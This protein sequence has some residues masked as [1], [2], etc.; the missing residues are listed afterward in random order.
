MKTDAAHRKRRA[1]SGPSAKETVTNS[2]CADRRGFPSSEA[3]PGKQRPWGKWLGYGING[4]LIL[5]AL[6]FLRC[7]VGQ[8]LFMGP[9]VPVIFGL[10]ALGLLVGLPLSCKSLFRGRKVDGV[11]GIILS[12]T[13]LPV[14]MFLFVLIARA[15]HLT[16]Y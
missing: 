14:F 8:N 5:L 2:L 11:I 3:A 7:R 6:S 10:P 16:F 4:S 9:L 15:K 1:V 13:P 12:L